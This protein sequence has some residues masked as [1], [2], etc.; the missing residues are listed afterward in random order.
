[1]SKRRAA[2]RPKP[3]PYDSYS[4]LIQIKAHI[5]NTVP[6]GLTALL[7]GWLM[8]ALRG[9]PTRT[10]GT[11]AQIAKHLAKLGCTKQQIARHFS[12]RLPEQVKPKANTQASWPKVH[13]VKPWEVR[14]D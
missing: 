2:K 13:W 1:M 8:I 7:G 12:Q 3:R 6:N 9:I 5:T 10:E 4:R 14:F 11:D